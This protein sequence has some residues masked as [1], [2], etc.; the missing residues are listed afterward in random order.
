MTLQLLLYLLLLC[1]P[2]L[3]MRASEQPILSATSLQNVPVSHQGRLREFSAYADLWLYNIY[4]STHIR[5][6]DRLLFSVASSQELLWKIQFQ[7][8]AFLDSAPLFWLKNSSLKELAELSLKPNRFSYRELHQAVQHPS[9]LAK[10]IALEF[11]KQFYGVSNRSRSKKMEL[12]NIYAGLWV[13]ERDGF[14]EILEAPP[15]GPLKTLVL[16]SLAYKA[17]PLS[18]LE[19]S[20]LAD[21]H[22]VLSSLRSYESLQGSYPPTEEAFAM[23]VKGW[24]NQGLAPKEIA[25][26]AE[27]RFPLRERLNQAG[28]ILK[29][30]PSKRNKGEWYAL[31][32]LNVQ[33]FNPHTQSL[34]PAP[35]FSAYSDALFRQLRATYFS[36]QHAILAKEA[37]SAQVLT[38]TLGELLREG[39]APLAGTPFQQVEGKALYYPTV[40]QLKAEAFYYKYPLVEVSLLFYGAALCGFLLALRLCSHRV[41]MGS[42]VL[43][44]AAFL[45]HSLVIALRCYILNRPPVS[46]MFETVIYVPWIAVLLSL[47]LRP[48]L[49]TPLLFVGSSTVALCLLVVLKLS[50][51]NSSMEN[52]QAVLDSQY[53]LII[54]VMMIVG[55]YG[56]FALSGVLAHAYIVGFFVAKKDSPWLKYAGSCILQTLYIGILLLIPGTILGGVWAAQSW[57][58][59]WDWDPK[60]SWAFISSC[61]YL[62]VVHAYRFGFVG[63]FGLAVGAITGLMSI[64]FTWYGV[65]YLLGTGLHSYGFGSGDN[66]PYYTYLAMECLFLGAGGMLYRNLFKNRFLAKRKFSGFNDRK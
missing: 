39:Y 24:T 3:G 54:H 23:A 27:D 7:G 65:N 60:E 41:E 64:S 35:N 10:M 34:E 55:S 30:L 1:A 51:V 46:N 58:R 48:F 18:A 15:K 17:H 56:V 32:A 5:K 28:T 6:S 33:I 44:A 29:M 12:K 45:C 53:W 47:V 50:N 43:L 22:S 49:K 9:F 21:M 25:R 40:G 38:H 57:G 36:L 37:G 62:V 14:L 8:H 20:L 66:W 2:A 61:V 63:Y 13:A 31:N 11:S 19:E 4:H 26:L 59:F 16:G 52:V 42:G